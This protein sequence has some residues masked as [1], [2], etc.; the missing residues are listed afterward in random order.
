MKKT[1]SV[2]LIWRKGIIT[3][4]K[5]YHNERET[6]SHRTSTYSKFW[7]SLLRSVL[8]QRLYMTV[9]ERVK[10]FTCTFIKTFSKT[11]LVKSK[12]LSFIVQWMMCKNNE[13]CHHFV[14]PFLRCTCKSMLF[15]TSTGYITINSYAAKYLIQ[16]KM[17]ISK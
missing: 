14:Q 5:S 2:H 17:C 13:I 12:G 10:H 3:I 4:H 15:I 16:N 6:S 1:C 11:T 8:C 7:P 9:K